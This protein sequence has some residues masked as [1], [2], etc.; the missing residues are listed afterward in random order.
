V[1]G[2]SEEE[3]TEQRKKRRNELQTL[4]ENLKMQ[5]EKLAE[6]LRKDLGASNKVGL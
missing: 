5:C 2:F 3:R 4:D 6:L 1:L